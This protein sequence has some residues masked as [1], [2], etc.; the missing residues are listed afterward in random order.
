M[1]QSGDCLKL[2]SCE[3]TQLIARERGEQGAPHGFWVSSQ[4]QTGGRGRRGNQWVST[5]GNLHLSVVLRP[6]RS[7]HWTW[8]A[9]AAAVGTLEVLQSEL[10]LGSESG[11]SIKWPNDLWLDGR[12]LAGFLCEVC[13]K[14]GQP[15]FLVLGLGLN[16][17]FAPQVSEQHTA[18]LLE[19]LG[20]PD[21]GELLSKLQ[22]AVPRA[23]AR[24]CT[25]LDTEGTSWVSEL[26]WKHSAFKPGA[27]VEW[28]EAG[29]RQTGIVRELGPH[30]EL[31]VEAQGAVVSLYSEE[32]RGLR[33]AGG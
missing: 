11:L 33:S 15:P 27:R 31:R 2:E 1:I 4:R 25:R 26:F 7:D 13:Q 19:V 8:V 30:G 10:G 24:A 3:S 29:A 20:T 22:D 23:V 5:P 18:A 32:I 6:A 12:K 14:R 17:G 28:G 9:I 21:S 16:V